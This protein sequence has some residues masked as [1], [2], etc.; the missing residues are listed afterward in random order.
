MPDQG[1]IVRAQCGGIAARPAATSLERPAPRHVKLRGTTHAT[2]LHR[3]QPAVCPPERKGDCGMHE[4]PL[5]RRR[6]SGRFVGGGSRWECLQID[7][8]VDF[9]GGTFEREV[10]VWQ[11]AF[12]QGSLDPRRLTAAQK[13]PFLTAM[14]ELKTRGYALPNG[15]FVR[16]CDLILG[17]EEV[18]SVPSPYEVASKAW[19]WG[20]STTQPPEGAHTHPLIR[21][22]SLSGEGGTATIKQL[23]KHLE[24]PLF[25]PEE[26]DNRALDWHT[27]EMATVCASLTSYGGV[28]GAGI[29]A[30]FRAL[31]LGDLRRGLLG[32]WM[33]SGNPCSVSDS[34]YRF[35]PLC[36]FLERQQNGDATWRS[37]VTRMNHEEAALSS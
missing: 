5:L 6:A 4:E 10:P 3:R 20:A 15:A 14:Q 7:L 12:L 24:S 9:G 25:A 29:W 23:Q 37:G 19:E 22:G 2:L 21:R 35:V 36:A 26:T 34:T 30:L 16:A 33:S 8:K 31:S 1:V 18:E 13:T 17:E 27:F 32:I 11:P 28:S